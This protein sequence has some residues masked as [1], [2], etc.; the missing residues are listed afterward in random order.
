VSFQNYLAIFRIL[1]SAIS[2]VYFL[3][4]NILIEPAA[5]NANKTPAIVVKK[6]FI[7][8][9]QHFRNNL[10]K[11]ISNKIVIPVKIFLPILLSNDMTGDFF[12]LI[13]F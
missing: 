11:V 6:V 4:L 2:F 3:I 12:Y 10:L 1:K 9:D 8:W 7:R 5:N 13:P